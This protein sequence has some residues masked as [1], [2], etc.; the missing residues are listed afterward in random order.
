MKRENGFA[1]VLAMAAIFLTGV[2]IASV[3]YGYGE[4][5]RAA[6]ECGYQ[7]RAWTECL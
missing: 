5:L 1:F 3:T 2:V 6:Q 7:D 4:Y